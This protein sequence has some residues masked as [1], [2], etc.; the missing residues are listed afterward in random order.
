M[1][2][3][4]PFALHGTYVNPLFQSEVD[5]TIK[6]HPELS[7]KLQK[8]RNIGAAN[9]IDSMAAIAKIEPILKGAQDAGKGELAMFVIY[10]LPN[11]DCSA[12]SSNGEILCEDNSCSQGLNTYRT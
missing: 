1:N 3:E 6:D 12:G 9:W 7:D 5:A 2:G 10:D 8:T 4:N 11:R